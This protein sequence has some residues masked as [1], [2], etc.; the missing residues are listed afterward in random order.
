[1]KK[2]EIQKVIMGPHLGYGAKGVLDLGYHA[3]GAVHTQ[4][5]ILTPIDWYTKRVLT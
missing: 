1:M 2:S 3:I 4:A 5:T